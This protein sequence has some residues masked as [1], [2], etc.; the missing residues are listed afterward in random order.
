MGGRQTGMSLIELMVALAVLAIILMIAL[1]NFSS[2]IQSGRVQAAADGFRRVTSQARDIAAQTGKRATLSVNASVSGCGD[3]AWSIT[4]GSTVRAC[5]TKADFAK[6]YEGVVLGGD[7]DGL[8]TVFSPSGVGGVIL[9][10][11]TLIADSS[12]SPQPATC[13]L[14]GGGSSKTLKVMAGGAV[15]V[16]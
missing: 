10:N 4:Q 1:P 12:G 6:R 3:A 16:Q 13:S 15:D 5:L 2:T 8:T 7:C 11:G 9:K 14:T